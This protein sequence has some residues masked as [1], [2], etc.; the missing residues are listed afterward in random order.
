MSSCASNKKQDYKK[1]TEQTQE[2][3]Q[4]DSFIEYRKSDDKVSQ[5]I[6]APGYLFSLSHI[7]D[8]A[9]K[10]NF[11][12]NWDGLLFLPYKV[13]LKVDGLSLNEAKKKIQDAYVKFF[14]SDGPKVTVRILQFHYYVKVKGLV[15]KP[16]NFLVRYNTSL[17]EVIGQAEGLIPFNRDEYILITVTK[18][19]GSKVSIGL[20]EYYQTGNSNM[21]PYWSGKEEIFIRKS[22]SRDLN[23]ENVILVTGEVR[24]PQEVPYKTDA[25]IYY[26]ITRAGGFTNT[27]DLAKVEIL[28]GKGKELKTFI[29]D[30]NKK[31]N[32]PV[33]YPGDR[34]VLHTDKPSR[35]E[36]ILD[37]F[38]DFST[39]ITAIAFLI[40]AL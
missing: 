15:K 30:L 23:Q 29:F 7:S 33:L 4:K 25:D 21:F 20:N 14:N 37:K 35:W 13:T 2:E 38:V 18:R 32:I 8:K 9:I 22:G 34:L 17:D 36:K 3:V 24:S 6:V 26:Y 39:I 31:D 27:S 19:D 16:G 1:F 40:I 11:R 28:R 5:D 12:V 10:G